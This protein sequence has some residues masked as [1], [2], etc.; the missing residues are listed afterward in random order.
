VSH[1][2]DPR[3]LGLPLAVWAG[4]LTAGSVL[5]ACVVTGAV[6][7]ATGRLGALALEALAAGATAGLV[8]SLVAVMAASRL[9]EA[10][11]SLH[12]DALWRLHD[13]S[14]PVTRPGRRPV[15]GGGAN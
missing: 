1:P 14:A 7:A 6:L 4:L 2:K 5:A 10:L 12:S 3:S 8:L 9:A 11:R 13:P 15:A